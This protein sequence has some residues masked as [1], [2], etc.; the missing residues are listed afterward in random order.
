MWLANGASPDLENVGGG[1]P[2]ADAASQVVDGNRA[3]SDPVTRARPEA[4]SR[5]PRYRASRDRLKR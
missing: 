3:I 5:F 1:H 4:R 2:I